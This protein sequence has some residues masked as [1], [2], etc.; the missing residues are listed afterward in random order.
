MKKI[1]IFNHKGGVSKTTTAFH[2]GWMLA[3]QGKK[4]LLVDGDP[5]CNLTALF[6]G[7]KKFDHYYE[8]EKTRNNNIKDGVAMVFNGQ[9]EP[10]QSFECP[11]AERNQNL[12]LLPGH[13]NLSEYESAL[14]LSLSSVFSTMKNLPGSFNELINL[15]GERY[16]VDYVIMDLNPA[17]SALNQILFLTA[18]SFLIPVNPDSFALMALKSLSRILPDWAHWA[19]NN[20]RMFTD[21]TYKL[22]QSHPL[23]LGIIYQRFNIRNGVATTPYRDKITELKDAVR[24]T[25]MPSFQEAEMAFLP[26]K[27]LEANIPETKELM[28]VKDYQGL[29]P[30]SQKYN[31]P[32]FELRDD[33]L[34]A[35]GAAL[36][37]MKA[38]RDAFQNM[39]EQICYKILTLLS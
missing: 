37:G 18:D 17:L 34:E 2:I 38:N 20:Q 25:L 15:I 7:L 16:S 23:F 13:M 32:V 6:L 24:D 31:V 27:Y 14:T 39:Y 29:A 26:H 28:E 4:V 30:K 33:E 3:N 35:T 5:Q 11:S 36:D 12:Y 22:P 21:A 10:I 1:V 8:D 19:N 9:P